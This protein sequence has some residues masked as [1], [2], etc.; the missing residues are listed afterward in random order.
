MDDR[1][2]NDSALLDRA[3]RLANCNALIWAI[4]NGLVSTTL[5]IALADALGAKGLTVSFILAAPR[6]AGVLRPIAPMAMGRFASRKWLCIA[7]YVGSCLVLLAMPPL[8]APG[9]LL[10]TRAAN[11]GALVGCWCVYHLLEFW[12][13]I[14]LWSW[15]GDWMPPEIRGR[16]TG[17][18]EQW[19]IA[20]QIVGIA[21]SVALYFIWPAVLVGVPRW[22]PLALSA[23][24]GALAMMASVVPLCGMT[25]PR[26]STSAVP[27]A[28]LRTCLLA[29]FDR[30]Y[31]P[32]VLFSCFFAFAN[33]LTAAAQ[34]LYPYRVAGMN[35]VGMA[36]VRAV[37]RGGQWLLAPSAGTWVDRFGA[38]RSLA[39]AQMI[40]ALGPLCYFMATEGAWW[41][42]LAAHLAWI[43]YAVVN[44]SLDTAKLAL[45][46]AA[47]NAPFMAAYYAAGDLS[48]AAAM[49]LG[50]WLYD[51]LDQIDDTESMWLSV[52][53]LLIAGWLLRTVAAPLALLIPA[54]RT[55]IDS[56]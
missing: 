21:A 24:L 51:R 16:L 7:C 17:R 45:A 18:R 25:S 19:L 4:G 29:L 53:T 32:L 41:W 54:S 11:L 31:R 20:G 46:P 40:V 3:M 8:A 10:E 13:T 30:P 37:M 23:A 33:G 26:L 38:S 56:T 1:P 35:Y 5:V 42:I 22:Q 55:A 6:L 52:G 48:L 44:V 12:G 2:A 9:W 28:P 50:G 14:A 27:T 15:L 36:S 34:G 47:N 43:A 39:A 49:I